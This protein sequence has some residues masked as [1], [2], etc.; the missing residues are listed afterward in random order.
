MSPNARLYRALIL[1]IV[2]IGGGTVGYHLIE[3][4]P[5][6]D[7]L[8]MTFITITTV[9]F[10]EVHPLS[11]Q[12]QHFTIVLL[13]F[14][15]LTLGYSVTVLITYV[16]GGQ[17]LQ[18][19]RKRKMKRLAKRL[20]DHYIICGSGNV[21]KEIAQEF[22]RNKARFV[23]IDKDPESSELSRDETVIFVK[24]DAV[25]DEVL[26]EAGIDRARGLVAALPDDESNVFIV[27]TA[28]QLNPSIT[29]VS[30]AVDERS[31][32]KLM[33]AGANR[34][35]SPKQIAGRR[36]ASILLNPSVVNFLDVIV[37][38]GEMDMRIEEV[39]IAAGSPLMGKT[40][41]EAGIG[42]HTGAV[43]IGIM[44]STGYTR[45]NPTS[46]TTLSNVELEEG[47]RLI[48]LGNDAQLS[49]L[50]SFVSRGK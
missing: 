34:V 7:C 6:Q 3:K 40:L 46:T 26:M 38:G 32:K 13:I 14:S 39:Q 9:G 42:T 36:M 18:S 5:V 15:I 48:A 27:L 17:I 20:R 43:I 21:G 35:V 19:V 49:S 22:Q 44:S 41:R 2:V 50:Q 28:R 30:Q 37:F 12:G 16:F 4:W 25:D 33:K 29:I 24:G 31:V 8:Y 11:D 45:V 47:D 1:L 23:M 10:G